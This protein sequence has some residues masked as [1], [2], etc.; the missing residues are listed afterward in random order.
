[1]PRLFLRKIFK[2]EIIWLPARKSLGFIVALGAYGERS[3][4][5]VQRALINFTR[6]HWAQTLY[7]GQPPL[8]RPGGRPPPSSRPLHAP[9]GAK[10]SQARCLAVSTPTKLPLKIILGVMEFL[11]YLIR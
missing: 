1:M 5:L 8:S 2:P 11:N 4:S 10:D 6:L 9:L 3:L 7:L